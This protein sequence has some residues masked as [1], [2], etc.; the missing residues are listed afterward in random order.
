MPITLY[1]A[2]GKPRATLYPAAHAGLEAE[3][4]ARLAVCLC[5]KPHT[6]VATAAACRSRMLT[7]VYYPSEPE[8]GRG[9]EVEEG[10]LYR[11]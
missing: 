11:V 3:R 6:S 8:H 10:P 2:N 7:V 5:A 1:D 4:L 9:P